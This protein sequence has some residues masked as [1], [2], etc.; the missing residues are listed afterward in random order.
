MKVFKSNPTNASPITDSP[1]FWFALFTAVGLSALLATGGRFGRRQANIEN[2]YQARSAVAAGKI[3]PDPDGIAAKPVG[4]PPVYSTPEQTMIP[5]WPLEILLG[6]IL[7]ASL[8]M[9]LRERGWAWPE[10]A[11]DSDDSDD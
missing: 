1:W 9:L 11:G 5:L 10:P 4:K 8:G 3:E 2:K 6:T 7:A